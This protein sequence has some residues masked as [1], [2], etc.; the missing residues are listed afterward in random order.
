M[1]LYHTVSVTAFIKK[2]AVMI[3]CVSSWH[4]LTLKILLYGRGCI[5]EARAYL[6]VERLLK[7]HLSVCLPVCA[8][9]L[10]KETGRGVWCSF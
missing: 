2:Q 3:K 4:R 7:V 9:I 1:G 10:F 6:V 5:Q 8:L